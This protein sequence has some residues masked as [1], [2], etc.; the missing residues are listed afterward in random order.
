MKNDIK[1]F[2]GVEEQIKE[3]DKQ[4]ETLK[5]SLKMIEMEYK[6]YKDI[7]NTKISDMQKVMCY[8][9]ISRVPVVTARSRRK[10]NVNRRGRR[11]SNVSSTK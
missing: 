7:M 1:N 3:K 6:E 5:R 9:L 10:I 2:E 8:I 4:L 11:K